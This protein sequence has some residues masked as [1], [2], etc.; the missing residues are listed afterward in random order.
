[1][2]I[3]HGQM[4]ALDYAAYGMIRYYLALRDFD[5]DEEVERFK[6]TKGVVTKEG[7][8]LPSPSELAFTNWAEAEGLIDLMEE[9]SVVDVIVRS[10]NGFEVEVI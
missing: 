3:I 10:E 5:L 9:G 6:A 4:I 2:E 1:M 7:L 8:C